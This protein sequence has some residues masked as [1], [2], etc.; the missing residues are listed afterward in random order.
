MERTCSFLLLPGWGPFHFCTNLS[1]KNF[2][3]VL[4]PSFILWYGLGT[5]ND[6]VS[7]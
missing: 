4:V 3:Q 7:P 2:Q 5:W 6:V 1:N